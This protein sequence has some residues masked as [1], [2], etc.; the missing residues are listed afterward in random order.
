MVR[1]SAMKGGAAMKR[2]LTVLVLL[3]ACALLLLMGAA[4]VEGPVLLMP[5]RETELP[6][7]AQPLLTRAEGLPAETVAAALVQEGPEHRSACLDAP[8][9]APILAQPLTDRNGYPMTGCTHVKTVYTA[10]PL[11]DM[12]G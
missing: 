4:L 10:C 3:T 1:Q 6:P 5:P 2:T 12:P 9:H 8:E 7:A 11:Q